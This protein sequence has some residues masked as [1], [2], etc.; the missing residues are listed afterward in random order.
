MWYPIVNLFMILI[1]II[2]WVNINNWINR[3]DKHI[4]TLVIWSFVWSIWMTYNCNAFNQIWLQEVS[5]F[6][7]SPRQSLFG[8]LQLM[9]ISLQTYIRSVLWEPFSKI[10]HSHHHL[11]L[12]YALMYFNILA[13][14]VQEGIVKFTIRNT[15]TMLLLYVNDVV[16]PMNI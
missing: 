12:E 10:F 5:F 14:F 7:Q 6:K 11:S 3:S 8:C 2:A 13:K 4:Q 1:S 15:I 9:D 16:L